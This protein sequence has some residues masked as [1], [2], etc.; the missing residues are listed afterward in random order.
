MAYKNKDDM[1]KYYQR[2][3]EKILKRTKDNYYKNP[4]KKREY[5]REYFKKNKVPK[6]FP[7]ENQKKYWYSLRFKKPWNYKGFSDENRRKRNIVEYKLW[8]KAVF[9][10]DNF[11]CQKTGDRGGQLEAHHINNFSEFP[12]L[13]FAIDNGITLSKD[14]HRKFHKICLS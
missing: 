5:G 2:N 14:A 12:E 4:E 8:R 7:T 13:R 6:V 3:K 10:R 9:E 1:K 11:T